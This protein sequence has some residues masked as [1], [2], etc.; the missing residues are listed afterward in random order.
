M[1][2]TRFRAF[3]S[4]ASSPLTSS[5]RQ[6][7]LPVMARSTLKPRA[8]A[9]A[10]RSAIVDFGLEWFACERTESRGAASGA[11]AFS[12]I[13][14]PPHGPPW[15]RGWAN[16]LVPR[17]ALVPTARPFCLIYEQPGRLW[18][19]YPRYPKAGPLARFWDESR[20]SAVSV[21]ALGALPNGVHHP[22]VGLLPQT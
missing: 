21:G 20:L 5:I 22:N 4:L 19:S 12:A 6:R 10:R 7:S 1:L 18:V 13:F 9:S 3:G 11:V 2:K 17:T 15:E 16:N 8:A 14:Y